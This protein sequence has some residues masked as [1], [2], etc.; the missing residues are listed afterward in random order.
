MNSF[1]G[2]LRL[3]RLAARRDRV[4]LPVWVLALTGVVAASASSIQSL[5]QTEQE[6]LSYAM[7]NAGSAVARVFNG[8]VADPTA[9]SITM[10]ET[11]SFT[12]V[13]VALMS[14]MAVVRHTRQN[15]ET[16]RAELIG[17]A[18]VGRHAM[19]TAALLVVVAANAVLALLI[20]GVFLALGLPAAGSL[21][22]GAA[23][24]AVGAAFAAVAAVTAQIAQTARGANG[25]AGAVLGAAFLLRALGDGLARPAGD[26]VTVESRW[27]SWLSPLGWG[28]QL[29]PFAGGRW[30]VFGLFAA[31]LAAGVWTAYR[32]TD[33][34][35]VGTGMLP[36]RRGPATA[37]RT[38]LSPLGL[39]W[40]L[41]RGVL[42]GWAV[43]VLL[44]AVS[45][46]PLGEEA[47]EL[48]ATSE[49]L[50]QYFAQLGGGGAALLDAF[51]AAVMG[52][53][54]IAVAGY[55]VQALLRI[56]TEET[57]PL[58]AVLATAVS[59]PR[60]ILGHILCAV[61]GTAALL[62]LTGAGV[63]VSY[64]LASGET[65]RTG[66]LIVAALAQ[67]PATLAVA[68]AV[69]AILGVLPRRAI[70][71]SWSIL[72]AC[73]LISQLGPVLELP[74]AVMNVSPFTHVP[75][76]PVADLAVTPLAALLAVGAAL[77]A[78]GIAAFRRR[79][80]AL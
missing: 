69:V 19:L 18:V 4:Q 56:R 54:G 2:T 75:F 32:L 66:E 43:G 42:L 16:G 7:S 57:G 73:L 6:R 1:T 51:F 68:G 76:L 67:L 13:L 46:G 70:A 22:A 25:L 60:W 55:T 23:F 31:L 36:V 10:T 34:R 5:Y 63:G 50:K 65:G 37:A 33:H 26:G 74:Q 62:L 28:Q 79:D 12:A 9:G 21:G 35:D 47:E 29:Q 53:F 49:E 61:A 38:L 80:L 78:G 72:I 41:Q 58:E 8:P 64:G 3:A 71:L 17:A 14:S 44:M 48:L 24:G 11:F 77:T 20:G 45:M 30:W 15:E 40:R 27:P 39:A 52:M 59:R